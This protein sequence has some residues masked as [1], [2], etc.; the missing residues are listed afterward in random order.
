MSDTG[1]HGLA[2]GTVRI[3]GYSARWPAAF[4]RE[5]AALRA[6]LG[7][8]AQDLQHIGSTAVPGMDAKPIIDIAVQVASF[9]DLSRIVESLQKLDYTHH[10]EYGLPGRQFF[11][12]GNPVKFHV[13]VVEKDSEHWR[14]WI[15]LRD[16]LRA[17]ERARESYTRFKRMLAAQHADNRKA[18]TA[19]KQPFIDR[20]M[21]DAESW[22]T[23]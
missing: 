14:R 22:L 9:R 4:D 11:T 21:Q 23:W 8:A 16:Y 1:I 5:A 13:H 19:A 10:G 7:D 17:N 3:T 6:A 12:R 20:M 18:Y 2:E 15:L